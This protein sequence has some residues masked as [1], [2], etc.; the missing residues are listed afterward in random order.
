MKDNMNS[1]ELEQKIRGYCKQN[2]ISML[3]LCAMLTIALQLKTK[4]VITEMKGTPQMFVSWLEKLGLEKVYFDISVYM[5][6]IMKD[7]D[8][9]K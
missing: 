1:E 5:M 3:D 2:D 9:D 6:E 7:K 4:Y 8:N